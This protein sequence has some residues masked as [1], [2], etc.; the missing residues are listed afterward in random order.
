[1]KRNLPIAVA[2]LPFHLYIWFAFAHLSHN[3]TPVGSFELN[4]LCAYVLS[5]VL[6]VF[7]ILTATVLLP[8]RRRLAIVLAVV[9]VVSHWIVSASIY[10]IRNTASARIEN[11]SGGH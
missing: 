2:T 6:L 11:Q 3:T 1:M 4:D 9:L 10:E 8:S 5:K 7:V